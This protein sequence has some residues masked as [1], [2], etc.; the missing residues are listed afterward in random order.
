MGNVAFVTL[1]LACSIKSLACG[2]KESK[3]NIIFLR[4][5]PIFHSINEM[6]AAASCYAI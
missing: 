6:E 2:G 5:M 4:V 3:K 1:F